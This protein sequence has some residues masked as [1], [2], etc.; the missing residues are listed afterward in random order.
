MQLSRFYGVSDLLE[1]LENLYIHRWGLEY[2]AVIAILFLLSRVAA[3]K[4]TLPLA[5][6]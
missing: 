3:T 1:K 6:A 5:N 4:M 2:K